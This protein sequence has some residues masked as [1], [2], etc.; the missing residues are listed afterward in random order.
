M[1]TQVD[2]WKQHPPLLQSRGQPVPALPFV[3]LFPQKSCLCCGEVSPWLSF[4]RMVLGHKQPLVP[5]HTL[6]LRLHTTHQRWHKTLHLVCAEKPLSQFSWPL[7]LM[8]WE[9]FQEWISDGTQYV[10]KILLG[11]IPLCSEVILHSSPFWE[12]KLSGKRYISWCIKR[13]TGD[14]PGPIKSKLR[15]S[16]SY[17]FDRN[18]I[19]G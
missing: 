18:R 16:W 14:S 4:A 3:L 19:L 13:H 6:A 17:F 2:C 8:G 10:T 11:L 1:N 7:H 9:P 12:R 15:C 5:W